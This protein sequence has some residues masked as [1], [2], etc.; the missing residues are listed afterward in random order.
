M[1]YI[2]EV[3]TGDSKIAGKAIYERD[4]LEQAVALFHKKMGTA[5]DSEL[6]T[7]E[8]CVVMDSHGAVYR[9]EEYVA[10]VQPVT[11]PVVEEPVEEPTEGE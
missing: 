6:Y 2:I 8:L 11:E 5:M 9:S 10:S 3:S 1:F 4:T 7:G